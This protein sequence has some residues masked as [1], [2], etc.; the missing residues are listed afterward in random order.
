[1]YTCTYNINSNFVKDTVHSMHSNVDKTD[2]GVTENFQNSC[3]GV[4]SEVA[5]KSKSELF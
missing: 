1:M 4:F 2:F 3:N 5:I